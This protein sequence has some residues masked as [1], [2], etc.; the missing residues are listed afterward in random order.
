MKNIFAIGL[1]LS[2][3]ILGCSKEKNTET[4]DPELK[5]E[6][7]SLV[8]DSINVEQATKDI[9]ETTNKLDELLNDL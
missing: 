5:K 2:L 6:I 3:L 8:L 9:E 1:I 7:Q 4:I